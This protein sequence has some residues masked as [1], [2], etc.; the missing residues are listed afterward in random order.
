MEKL[1]PS[2]VQV[3]W[4][5]QGPAL[6]G[7]TIGGGG[8][9]QRRQARQGGAGRIAMQDLQQEDMD[10]SYRIKNAMAPRITQA[11]TDMVDGFRRQR[12]GHIGLELPQDLRNTEG[13]PWP[14]VKMGCWIHSI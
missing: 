10:G 14:P 2:K 1:E 12:L 8:E 11:A 9:R 3:R 5:R 6:V 13:H 4:P 7:Q